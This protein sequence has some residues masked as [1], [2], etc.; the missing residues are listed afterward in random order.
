MSD[1]DHQLDWLAGGALQPAR[2]TAKAANRKPSRTPPKPAP[3]LPLKEKRFL[4]VVGVPKTRGDC[5][6]TTHQAC[7]FVLCRAH[8]WRVDGCDRAGRPGLA[9]VP[10]DERG[11]TLA[12]PGQAGEQRP[13]T[14]LWPAWLE[15]ERT[16]KVV[17]VRDDDG[18]VSGFDTY[19]PPRESSR[20][21]TNVMTFVDFT[22]A[23]EEIKSER[24][25]GTWEMFREHTHDGEPLEVRD[26]NGKLCGA[27]ELV[28][29]G[30]KFRALI[31]HP[32]V[33]VLRRVRGVPSCSLDLID[34]HGRMTNEQIGDAVGRHRTLVA[35]EV[36]RAAIKMR[37]MGVDVRDVISD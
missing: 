13:G 16:C 20:L 25:I 17:L 8:L 32:L 15:L 27:A 9:N 36:R 37:A 1:K 22:S 4:P 28:P 14:T 33:V 7:P 35:R 6:D 12:T 23:G 10:R 11:H 21:A 24:P 18:Q 26:D 2:V 19:A 29:E 3:S 30:A 5:P 31:G 34:K